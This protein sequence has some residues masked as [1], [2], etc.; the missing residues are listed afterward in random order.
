[1]RASITRNGEEERQ[2]SKESEEFASR[3]GLVDAMTGP[4]ERTLWDIKSKR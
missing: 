1:M 3:Y 2:S 4:I